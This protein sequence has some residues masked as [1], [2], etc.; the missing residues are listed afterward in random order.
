MLD[1]L[2]ATAAALGPAPRRVEALPP[3]PA[4]PPPP[5]LKP[6]DRL[7]DSEAD[8]ERL[9]REGSVVLS[10][11]VTCND[12]LLVDGT[13]GYPAFVVYA[14]R[15]GVSVEVLIDAAG[16]IERA[17]HRGAGDPELGEL[18]KALAG[19]EAR[20]GRRLPSSVAQ[21]YKLRGTTILVH[22]THL[23][24][25]ILAAE[26]LPLLV[27]PT[28]DSAVLLPVTM[29]AEDLRTAWLHLAAAS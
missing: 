14:R 23:P 3:S 4:T 26:L 10:W 17:R 12:A 18:V 6:S 1:L 29:W 16:A 22:R 13:V 20:P 9:L 8:R 27:H 2:A 28:L 21:G 15:G 11:V 24:R 5:W 25:P 7:L 19:R